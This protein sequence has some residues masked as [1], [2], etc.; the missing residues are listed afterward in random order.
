MTDENE[1][2]IFVQKALEDKRKA[3]GVHYQTILEA[4]EAPGDGCCQVKL[5]QCL[6]RCTNSLQRKSHSTLIATVLSS[7]WREN[8]DLIG[9]AEVFA[10]NCVSGNA[11]LLHPALS[12]LVKKFVHFPP[13]SAGK[14]PAVSSKPPSAQPN[15]T[16]EDATFLV[17]VGMGRE[18]I[19]ILTKIIDT[20]PTATSCLLPILREN[21][22]HRRKGLADQH[23][24]SSHLLDVARKV[25]QLLEQILEELV[26]RMLQIDVE[27]DPELMPAQL[28]D[29]SAG[30]HG[31]L[32]E[33]EMDAGASA[34][35]RER[36]E[37]Y[38]RIEKLDAMMSI[39]MQFLQSVFSLNDDA[40]SPIKKSA[41]FDTL[42]RLFEAKVLTTFKSKYT[43]FLI[44]FACSFKSEYDKKLL[45]RL[46]EV[47]I[48]KDASDSSRIA[49]NCYIGSYIARAKRLR[50]ATAKTAIRLLTT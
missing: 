9:A 49:A 16:T 22:P 24:Y 30:E 12:S 2:A 19:R 15:G 50:L 45:Q 27:I 6:S 32:F 10:I 39:A 4:I 46:I 43:Q 28:L 25:P 18:V 31:E 17:Q 13:P 1:L 42:L 7:C 14:R 47:S 23:N 26:D 38:Q 8:A 3:D 5:V 44:F 33:L 40:N 35:E 34:E 36:L 11:E 37:N 41:L 21:F 29:S 20:Y 48:S